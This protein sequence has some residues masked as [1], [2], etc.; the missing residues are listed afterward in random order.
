MS[1]YKVP[2]SMDVLAGQ[3][4]SNGS[5]AA[6][7]EEDAPIEWLEYDF[8]KKCTNKSELQRILKTLQS[9]KHG[10]YEHLETTVE[11][12]LMS[13]MTPQER[14]IYIAMNHEPSWRDQVDARSDLHT[15]IAQAQGKSKADL[16]RAPHKLPPAR[17]QAK[18]SESPQPAQASA[19]QA[20]V[21]AK[22]SSGTGTGTSAELKRDS[23][24]EPFSQY[25]DR[26]AKVDVDAEIAKME[27]DEAKKA[28]LAEDAAWVAQAQAQEKRAAELKK[29]KLIAADIDQLPAAQ[30]A[31]LA[32]KEKVKGNESFKAG[33]ID[34]SIY[35]Y[36][37]A[38]GK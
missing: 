24:A 16:G 18:E 22:A 2:V 34:E 21:A 28:A 17:G 4:S 5:S 12:K 7:G 26:W 20:T 29:L 13:L 25:Y 32:E 35:H 31:M 1:F 37:R 15:W 3:L 6:A 38:L 10:K 30:R 8:V 9:G 33:E 19:V 14:S 11:E 27:S 36:S 23:K